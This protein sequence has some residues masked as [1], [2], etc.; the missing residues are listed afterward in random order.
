MG[1]STD[2]FFFVLFLKF[3]LFSV[4]NIWNIFSAAADEL[5]IAEAGEAVSWLHTATHFSSNR[6]EMKMNYP[7][8]FTTS[9]GPCKLRIANHK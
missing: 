6:N 7:K 1:L 9:A 8:N 4:K 5:K 2:D 3:G